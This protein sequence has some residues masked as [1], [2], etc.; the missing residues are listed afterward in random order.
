VPLTDNDHRTA[1]SIA[2][3]LGI[4]C[5][6]AEV[7]PR[8]RGQEHQSAA[9]GPGD[10]GVTHVCHRSGS[11][12]RFAERTVGVAG[13]T[14]GGDS[15]AARDRAAPAAHVGRPKLNVPSHELWLRELHRR[16]KLQEFFDGQTRTAPIL[17]PSPPCSPPRRHRQQASLLRSSSR[18]SPTSGPLDAFDPSKR[19]KRHGCKT[20]WRFRS[21]RKIFV[22][23]SKFVSCVRFMGMRTLGRF[24]SEEIA[25]K[26]FFDRGS[27][28]PTPLGNRSGGSPSRPAARADAR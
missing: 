19:P 15:A 2:R 11:A 23:A 10:E 25:A 8:R 16:D 12:C 18:N 21:V 7:L 5:V 26:G 22:D 6:I 17:V 20:S 28:R 13:R 4:G 27:R 3:Q 24:E 1:N 14:R 9:G